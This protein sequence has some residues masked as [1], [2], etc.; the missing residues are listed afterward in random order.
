MK[1]D[2]QFEDKIIKEVRKNGITTEDG[3]S[4]HMPDNSPIKPNVGMV[5]RFYGEG[6]GR[7]VRG[8]FID[9]VKIFYN[10]LKQQ[11]QKDKQ[12]CIDYKENKKKEFEE[13]KAI[14]DKDYS[15][16]PLVF[17]KRIDRFRKGNKNFRWEYESYEMMCCTQAVMIANYFKAEKDIRW[18]KNLDY[19]Q[20]KKWLPGLDDGHSG[21]SFGCAVHLAI[22]YVTKPALVEK[23]HGAL[24]PLVGCKDYGCTHR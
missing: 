23:A 24:T 5:A 10:T 3:W 1:N 9:G 12:W 13:N 8:L 14:L 15:L 22:L 20:Q 7:P 21:N 18:W 2:L 4:F 6:I 11:K 19:K 16:L 17:Q